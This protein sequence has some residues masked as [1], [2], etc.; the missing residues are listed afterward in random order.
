MYSSD[1]NDEFWFY[2]S[3]LLLVEFLIMIF[4]FVGM[5][6]EGNWDSYHP[7]NFL[8][9]ALLIGLVIF[10]SIMCI[11]FG[12]KCGWGRKSRKTKVRP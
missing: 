10:T 4:P 1:T 3:Q 8:T 12:R 7:G 6:E 5:I 2:M 11:N 9:L